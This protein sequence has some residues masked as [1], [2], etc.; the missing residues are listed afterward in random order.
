MNQPI[1]IN[2]RKNSCE[3]ETVSQW[4]A[5]EFPRFLSFHQLLVSLSFAIII[6]KYGWPKI[7]WDFVNSKYFLLTCGQACS[8]ASLLK[9]TLTCS[10]PQLSLVSTEQPP[11]V[12]F[13]DRQIN[14]EH[15]LSLIKLIPHNSLQCSVFSNRRTWKKCINS[16]YKLNNKIAAKIMKIQDRQITSMIHQNLQI[17][18]LL[19]SLGPS[20]SVLWCQIFSKRYDT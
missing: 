15:F 9:L 20:Q 18:T 1:F 11:N 3:L 17:F 5:V 14:T 6:T 8:Q 16:G 4:C 12:K 7:L 19:L 2:R 10:L 13:I